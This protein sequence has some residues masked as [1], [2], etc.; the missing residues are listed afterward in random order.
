MTIF[1]PVQPS[2]LI[3]APPSG[4][5]SALGVGV[6]AVPCPEGLAGM[7]AG[8]EEGVCVCVWGGVPRLDP[9]ARWEVWG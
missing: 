5:E 3:T 6:G 9:A 8:N 7:E 1:L 2:F 4:Q